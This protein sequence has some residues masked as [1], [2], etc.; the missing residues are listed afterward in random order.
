MLE[1]ISFDLKHF[2]QSGVD[3]WVR[4][5]SVA[6]AEVGIDGGNETYSRTEFGDVNSV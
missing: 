4:F 5:G 1:R 6:V 2:D 3:V